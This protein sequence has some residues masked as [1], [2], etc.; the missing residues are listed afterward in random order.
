MID[1]CESLK[2]SNPKY[3]FSAFCRLKSFGIAGGLGEGEAESYGQ[4][5]KMAGQGAIFP[6][7]CGIRTR[8]LPASW[9]ALCKI[10]NIVLNPQSF[11]KKN[12]HKAHFF[13]SSTSIYDLLVDFSFSPFTEKRETMRQ[14]NLPLPCWSARSAAYRKP[15]E[16]SYR[17]ASFLAGGYSMGSRENGLIHMLLQ[18]LAGI[19]PADGEFLPGR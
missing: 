15:P 5:R 3:S 17:K 19:L 6:H 2:A 7:G 1:S 10:I 18:L 14:A 16:P 8:K 9:L 13:V 4:H 12:A 11:N